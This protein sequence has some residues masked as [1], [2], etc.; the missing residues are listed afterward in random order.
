[1]E[2]KMKQYLQSIEQ[3]ERCGYLV[4]QQTKQIWNIQLDMALHLLDV[5]K[6][7][8][9]KIWAISGTMLGAVR[10]HGFIPWDDDMDFVM[11]RDDYDKLLKIAKDEFKSP[12]FFQCAYTE[13]GYYRGHSQLRYEDTTMILP[14]EAKLGVDFNMGVC[15]DIF[16]ADGFPEDEAE[17]KF[18]IG[19]RDLILDYLWCRH[20][21]VYRALRY[22]NYFKGLFKLGRKAFWSDIKLYTYLED[23]FRKYS[24]DKYERSCCTLFA[25]KPRWV[26]RSE[27]FDKTI[28]MPFETIELPI[29]EKYHELLSHEYGDYMKFV[30]GGS[31]HS[32]PIIDV[33]KPYMDYISG[34]RMS[35]IY[36]YYVLIGT[37]IKE[38]GVFTL[39]MLG[40]K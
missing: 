9:L 20:Y 17:R 13:K 27:W 4:T 11:F 15:I 32:Q 38:A 2:Y 33:C 29:P 7:H 40:V 34:M 1:M 36:A 5:C 12:Y 39:K 23:M 3:E 26:R 30:V 21:P 37:K 18:L 35:Y 6:R 14:D 8:E 16:V 10:H 22:K 28:M 24:I 19:Q 25:Y 31:T